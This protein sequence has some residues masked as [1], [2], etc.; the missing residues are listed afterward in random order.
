M[1]TIV[2]VM[3]LSFALSATGSDVGRMREPGKVNLLIREIRQEPSSSKRA[4]LADTLADTFQHLYDMHAAYHVSKHTIKELT[5]LLEDDDDNVRGMVAASLGFIGP[6]AQ[7]SVPA[8]RRALK[9]VVERKN[10]LIR[11]EAVV[12][13][14]TADSEAPIRLALERIT[15][16]PG[17]SFPPFAHGEY[18]K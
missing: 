4:A 10:S 1:P 3:L 14:Q 15:G 12:I 13:V 16:N 6:A 9:I 5:S 17:D 2:C 11:N 8:L 18:Q 7:S